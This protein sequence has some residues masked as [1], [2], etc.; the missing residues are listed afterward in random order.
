MSNPFGLSEISHYGSMQRVGGKAAGF[1]NKKFFH[2]SSLRNQEKLW[3]AQTEDARIRRQEKEL[4]NQREEERQ[5]EEL[6][7][8]MYLSG[9]SGSPGGAFAASALSVAEKPSGRQAT[10]QKEAADEFK[11]RKA[12][13]RADKAA[14]AVDGAVDVDAEPA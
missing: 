11:R 2:P 8:Q 12:L 1:I 14:A 9:Q 4:N 5:V 13:L 10:E 7:K 6:R 3:K